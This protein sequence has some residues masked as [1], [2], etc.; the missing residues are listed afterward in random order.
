MIPARVPP[1][2]CSLCEKTALYHVQG[3]GFCRNHFR[4]AKAA[5]TR[6]MVERSLERDAMS[7]H[8][9]HR[10]GLKGQKH[11]ASTKK[12]HSPTKNQ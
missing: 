10:P 8:A 1:M 12:H 4:D 11:R 5:Q 3:R 6:V 9:A 7:G 2:N